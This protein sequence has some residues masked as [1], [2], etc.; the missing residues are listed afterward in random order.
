M[1]KG[2]IK[3]ITSL[4]IIFVIS[5]SILTVSYA[6]TGIEENPNIKIQ[7]DGKEN[8]FSSIPIIIKGRTLLPLREFLK[9]GRA[10][11]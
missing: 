5:F 3:F 1:F 2:S 10:H 9:I 11:V 6:E 4:V 7:I 8:V